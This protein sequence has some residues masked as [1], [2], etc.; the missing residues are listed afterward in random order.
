[1]AEIVA[2][3]MAMMYST[4]PTLNEQLYSWYVF[5][6]YCFL[7]HETWCKQLQYDEFHIPCE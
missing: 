7:H 2:V 3:V 1:M 4:S 5:V 6:T